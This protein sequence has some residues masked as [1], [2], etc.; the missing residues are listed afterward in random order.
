MI[1][2]VSGLPRSGTSLMMQMLYAGGMPVLTD[3]VRVPDEDNPRGYFEWEPVKRLRQEPRRILEADGKVVKLVSPLL[4][5]LPSGCAYR[6]I[7]MLRPLK[8]IL[9]SQEE[10]RRRRSPAESPHS[11][12]ILQQAYQKHLQ[13]V[14]AWMERQ[15]QF[16]V[17]RVH[18][19]EVIRDPR[20]QAEK[21]REFLG[22]NLDLA[23]M[24]RQVDPS[25]YRQN[26]AVERP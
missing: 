6:V 26:S 25:L 17:L 13:E 2:F 19:G 20:S 14:F 4:T 21:I 22:I 16:A 3:H 9:T 12:E 11:E 23:A 18:F 8:E 1:T 15:S 10:M 24:I 5:S 7:F